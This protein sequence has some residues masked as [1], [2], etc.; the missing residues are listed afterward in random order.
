MAVPRYLV[1]LGLLVF[2]IAA[3]RMI[4]VVS[5]SWILSAVTGCSIVFWLGLAAVGPKWA[6]RPKDAPQP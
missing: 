3:M 2:V 4:S 6:H 5:G 1:T